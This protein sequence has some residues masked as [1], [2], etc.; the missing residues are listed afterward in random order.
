MTNGLPRTQRNPE[1]RA[2]VAILVATAIWG[3]A[4]PIIKNTL[5][6]IPPFSFLFY[7][8]LIVCIILFPFMYLELRRHNV[9]L[10]EF[11]AL[12]VS[13]ILGQSSLALLFLGLKYTSSLEVAVLGIIAPLLMVVAG[14]YFFNERV[15]KQIQIGLVIATVGTLILALGPILDLEATPSSRM[16]SVIGNSLI[17]VYNL[18][19]TGHVLWSKRIRGENSP[20]VDG[21]AKF[22][23]IPVPRKKYSSELVTGV[24]FYVGLFTMI[25]FY[26]L[27]STGRFGSSS[28]SIFELNGNGWLGL[29]YMAILSSIVAYGL[30]EWSLK[31][32]KVS[33]TVIFSYISPLF[34]LPAAFFILGELPTKDIVLGA[35]VVALGILVAE[36]KKG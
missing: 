27:E 9:S 7:R 32:L 15:K 33:D 21:V 20:R 17:V 1:V 18:L 36:K 10:R 4:P 2:L 25:P 24:S 29:L 16:E 6:Y 13:G 35:G 12:A 22:F 11:P 34:T 19:W 26:I 30:F 5:D 28:F 14:H 3:F 8:F 31:Y 23:G